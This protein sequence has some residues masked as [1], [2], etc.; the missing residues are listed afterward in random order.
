ME[1]TLGL[2][3]LI[4]VRLKVRSNLETSETQAYFFPTSS[5]FNHA[6]KVH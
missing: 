3:P 5:G 2:Q 4:A 1:K 6:Y